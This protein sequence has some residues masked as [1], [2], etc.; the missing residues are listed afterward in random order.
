MPRGELV[1]QTTRSVNADNQPVSDSISYR[2]DM[3][4]RLTQ[5]THTQTANNQPV[6][7]AHKE[8]SYQYDGN[9][10]LLKEKRTEGGATQTIHRYYNEADQLT[11]IKKE[12]PAKALTIEH[13]QDGKIVV[14]HQGHRYHYDGKGI[15]LSVS[16]P[17]G[18]TLV[19]FFYWPDGLL[20][21]TS[22]GSMSQSFYYHTN[23][24]VQTVD[25]NKKLHDYI[26]YGNRFL[27]TLKGDGGE[28]LFTSNRSTGARLRVDEK[29]KQAVDLFKYEGYGQSQSPVDEDSGSSADFLWN[30]E[31]RE[32]KTG[33]VYLRHRFYH[34]ELR[35][36]VKRDDQ[37]IDN[38]YAYAAANPVQFVDPLGHRA[39][40]SGGL[41]AMNLGLGI[42]LTALTATIAILGAAETGGTSLS[43]TSIIGLFGAGAGA[44][45]SVA[46]I[47]SQV[48]FDLG[49]KRVG[50]GLRYFGYGMAGVSGL[51][52]IA[53]VASLIADALSESAV[54][55]IGET[56]N[57][58]L[59]PVNQLDTAAAEPRI[60][61]A[62]PF[63][64]AGKKGI[65]VIQGD[66]DYEDLHYNV[67]AYGK[68]KAYIM[69]PKRYALT[70]LGD[71]TPEEINDFA[72]AGFNFS[73]PECQ[74]LAL[75]AESGNL[76]RSIP[77]RAAQDGGLNS[78]A[79]NIALNNSAENSMGGFTNDVA[80]N[81]LMTDH[82]VNQG[83]GVMNISGAPDPLH[84]AGQIANDSSNVNAQH[85]VLNSSVNSSA[86]F[87]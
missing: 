59:K 33:L 41:F 43:L 60:N 56:E 23:G 5:E 57:I 27:G 62:T 84:H 47:G 15:L 76:Y 81:N 82:S 8:I 29:G 24:Q 12:T 32:H 72:K 38:L 65:K 17:K 75:Q 22:D 86:G 78:S 18:K 52:G 58:A 42:V 49:D 36:F 45:S 19:R 67:R 44:M 79:P 3:L 46:T 30:Q 61:R 77:P 63:L 26:R 6:N 13:D 73:D 69:H 40:D 7:A 74:D 48:A 21:H 64:K 51:Y 68:G 80:S 37:N 35:R 39:S 50:S 66:S 25:K 87:W 9:N 11:T 14:D 28:H 4:K 54:E 53:G 70:L 10:N 83:G 55:F 34:P 31:F 20:A 85:S 2:Y 16:D 1:K 71:L